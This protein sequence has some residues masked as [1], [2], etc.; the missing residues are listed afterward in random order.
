MI[1]PLSIISNDPTVGRECDW[2]VR[3]NSEAA[4]KIRLQKMR[5][6]TRTP[7]AFPEEIIIQHY[8]FFAV[9]LWT[10]FPLNLMTQNLPIASPQINKQHERRQGGNQG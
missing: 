7:E 5:I 6:S 3:G 4:P 1:G 10:S 2:T 8:Y 9:A